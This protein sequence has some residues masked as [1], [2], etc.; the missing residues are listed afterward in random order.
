MQAAGPPAPWPRHRPTAPVPIARLLTAPGICSKPSR[1][2]RDTCCL[3]SR[4]S[5]VTSPSPPALPDSLPCDQVYASGA[6]CDVSLQRKPCLVGGGSS[7][8]THK[9]GRKATFSLATDQCLPC[10][11]CRPSYSGYVPSPK[12]QWGLVDTQSLQAINIEAD[13]Q[14]GTPPAVNYRC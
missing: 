9:V 3:A 7:P 13:R 8:F 1:L 2:P 12:A 14:L 6:R 5:S 4:F 10:A 11:A